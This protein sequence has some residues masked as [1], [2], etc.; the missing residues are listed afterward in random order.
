MRQECWLTR[1]NVLFHCAA[2]SPITFQS[3]LGLLT[4]RETTDVGVD[5]MHALLERN[6]LP[7][8]WMRL[9]NLNLKERPLDR[10]RLKTP[11]ES[12]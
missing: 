5:R 9:N 6:D 3:G 11:V 4:D 8:E 7:Q 10:L 1:N 2:S 12:V